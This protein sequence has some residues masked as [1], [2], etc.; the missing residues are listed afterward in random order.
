MRDAKS[1]GLHIFL[2]PTAPAAKISQ[3]YQASQKDRFA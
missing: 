1:A 3:T 2:G